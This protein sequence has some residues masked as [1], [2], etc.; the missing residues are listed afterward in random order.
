MPPSENPKGYKEKEN[1]VSLKVSPSAPT[2]LRYAAPQEKQPLQLYEEDKNFKKL[3]II[4]PLLYH[5][6]LMSVNTV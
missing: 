3:K 4:I 6:L 1:I 2:Y 5:M